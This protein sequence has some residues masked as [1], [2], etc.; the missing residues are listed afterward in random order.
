VTRET[1]WRKP[2]ELASA[3]ERRAIQE[4]ERKQ[5]DFFAAMEGNILRCMEKGVVPGTPATQGG[6]EEE[7]VGSMAKVQKKTVKLLAKSNKPSR[8]V[9]T[10]SS[11][12]NDVLA[13]V[14][15]VTGDSPPKVQQGGPSPTSVASL[16]ASMVRKPPQD[17]LMSHL[18]RV[19]VAGT[20]MPFGA[21]GEVRGK[22]G[23]SP[24]CGRL[25]TRWQ[26]LIF[27]TG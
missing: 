16:P 24:S 14:T 5:K 17:G 19:P 4:K 21:S 9:R 25:Q 12:N 20:P 8:A 15:K 10:I 13:E 23:Q 11:M 27:A 18:P 22:T 6:E 2:I 26:A 1:Q 7:T 3:E